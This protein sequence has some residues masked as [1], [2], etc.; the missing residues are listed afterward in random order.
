MYGTP[1]CYATY[2]WMFRQDVRF[3]M[4]TE[5]A[6]R[7]RTHIL[8]HP[9][10]KINIDNTVTWRL[11]AGIG[12][13]EEAD[14]PSPNPVPGLQHVTIFILFLVNIEL[15]SADEGWYLGRN[16]PEYVVYNGCDDDSLVSLFPL[17]VYA[18]LSLIGIINFILWES[19]RF[20]SIYVALIFKSWH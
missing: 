18:I 19:V 4:P 20:Y 10:V 5:W 13:Q 3:Q 17:T 16:G 9:V 2:L 8:L 12:E 14:V 6:L 11:N 7:S 15:F 1:N